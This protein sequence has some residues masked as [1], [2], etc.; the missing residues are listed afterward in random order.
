MCGIFGILFKKLKGMF[1]FAFYDKIEKKLLIVRDR[2]GIKP[3]YVFNDDNTLFEKFP[4]KRDS[5]LNDVGQGGPLRRENKRWR[6]IMEHVEK[7]YMVEIESRTPRRL[8]W[9]HEEK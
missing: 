7:S 1:A 4:E 2:F 3:L 6:I 5:L 8:R 9:K